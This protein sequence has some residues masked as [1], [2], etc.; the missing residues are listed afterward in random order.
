MAKDNQNPAAGAAA[1]GEARATLDVPVEQ[2]MG[3]E[4][5]DAGE[6]AGD[7]PP[8]GGG[9]DT[10]AGGEGEGEGEGEGADDTSAGAGGDDT[11]AGGEGG[12]K[13][14]AGDD[15]TA[16]E[17][18]D[19]T[20]AGGEGDDTLAGGAG[21]G[22]DAAQRQAA[23]AR[24]EEIR[25]FQN[26]FV[27]LE[28]NQKLMKGELDPVTDPADAAVI[29]KALKTT[30]RGIRLLAQEN[31]ELRGELRQQGE[32][33]N[34]TRFWTTWGKGNADVGEAEGRKL[35]DAELAGVRKEYKGQSDQVIRAVASERFKGRVA[36]TRAQK[37]AAAAEQLRADQLKN[38]NRAGGGGGGA[39]G[40]RILPKGT[41]TNQP[42]K[43]PRS[44]DEKLK[45]GSYGNVAG[46][47]A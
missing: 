37:K 35:W 11:L 23:A 20:T 21:E 13:D 31:A 12:G 36:T 32:T 43:S 1:G 40:T 24:M 28:K 46:A 45:A 15:T 41:N 44:V 30:L 27:E 7:T 19:D 47:F 2:E 18:K 42:P 39:G 29:N 25:S 9:D 26:D 8:G 33:T 4:F 34:D 16:G 3:M 22:G 5:D 38:K 10:L 14:K 6:G 17:G